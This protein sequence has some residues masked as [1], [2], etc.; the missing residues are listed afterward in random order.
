MSILDKPQF[1]AG[2]RTNQKK[3]KKKKWREISL[4]EEEELG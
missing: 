3:K 1:P 4:G 2:V